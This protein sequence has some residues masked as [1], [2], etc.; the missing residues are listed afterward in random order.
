MNG[1]E[2]NKEQAQKLLRSLT[3][4]DDRFLEEAMKE[5]AAGEGAQVTG[6]GALSAGT[7]SQQ[8][9]AKTPSAVRKLRRYSTWALTAAACLTVVIVGRYVTLN[10]EAGL[11]NE[12]PAVVS[13][14]EKITEV[15]E[16]Y[17]EVTGA[18]AP[19]ADA[20]NEAEEAVPLEAA[21]EAK[22]QDT[23]N[24]VNEA[25]PPEASG[26]M[27]GESPAEAS[28][29]LAAEAVG[30]AYDAAPQM[31]DEADKGADVLYE[32]AQI[33]NPFTDT[34]TLEEAQEIAGFDLQVPD[35]AAPYT[36]VN[37][38]AV[39]G[40]MLEII[41]RDRKGEE[42]YRIRKAAGEDDIS[43]DYNEYAKEKTIRLSDGT[44]VTLR[45]DKDD[46]WSVAVWTAEDGEG[47]DVYSFAVCSGEKT[48][49]S[50][51]VKKMAEV[52]SRH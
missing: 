44:K 19:G 39:E 7:E 21:G 46:E 15:P 23:V 9:K 33:A 51:E 48:F 3:D 34:K 16:M 12:Q 10:R 31:D 28:G 6:E 5:P 8:V 20:V 11:K 1:N 50:E 14:E 36:V 37:Y 27:A 26:E 43:G 45:G 41:F 38:R 29:E 2:K 25:V 35:A 4:I 30:E 47:K 13:D 49:T 18:E 22:S 52:M 17:D 42:G 40:E 32:S 24:A